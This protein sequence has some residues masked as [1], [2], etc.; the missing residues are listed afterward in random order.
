MGNNQL[1]DY[2]S[3]H[4]TKENVLSASLIGKNVFRILALSFGIFRLQN[5]EV[6]E[7]VIERILGD[8]L[9]VIETKLLEKF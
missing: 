7:T 2:G 8:D 1:K 6:L 3:Q 4:A 9:R 5:V